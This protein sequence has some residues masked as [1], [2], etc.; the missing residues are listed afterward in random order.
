MN[1]LLVKAVLE[2]AQVYTWQL[3]GLGMLRLYLNKATRLH[4]WHSGF[5]VPG[6]STIHT[7]PWDFKSEVVAGSWKMFVISRTQAA[8]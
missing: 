4:V 7:H 2:H 6:A 1:K 8:K 3:Q 5:S